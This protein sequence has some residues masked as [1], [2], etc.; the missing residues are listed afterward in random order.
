MSENSIK[1]FDMEHHFVVQ[2]KHKENSEKLNTAP[3]DTAIPADFWS[4]PLPDSM[5]YKPARFHRLRKFFGLPEGKRR[6]NR[7]D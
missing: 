5:L 6:F 4:E 1:D 3:D 2:N 7:A